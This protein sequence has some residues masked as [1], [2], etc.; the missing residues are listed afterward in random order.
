MKIRSKAILLIIFSCV[1]FAVPAFA[2]KKIVRKTAAKTPVL[3]PNPTVAANGIDTMMATRFA[4]TI[5]YKGAKTEISS[6]PF[7]VRDGN[8]IQAGDNKLL[9]FYGVYN[10]NDDK[11]F[12]FNAA[13]PKFA[14]GVYTIS[15]VDL[16]PFFS[17]TSSAFP[18]AGALK[19]KSGTIEITSYAAGAGFVEGTFSGLCVSTSDD[20]T[21]GDFKISGSFRLKKRLE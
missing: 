2:Q 1:F 5:E 10:N 11:R 9:L 13:I 12:S 14:K 4:M 20:G 7:E 8:T 16:N 3:K 19:A 18:N 15:D 21:F 17:I 6:A